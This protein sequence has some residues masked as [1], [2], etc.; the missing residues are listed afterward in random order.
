MTTKLQ[1]VLGIINKY[2]YENNITKEC[3]TNVQIIF[4]YM[5]THE[6]ITPVIIKPVIAVIK[7]ENNLTI[8]TNH[9]VIKID[10][11]IIDPSYEYNKYSNVVYYEN[12]N[13]FIINTF[14]S[15][16]KGLYTKKM[17]KRAF[18]EFRKISAKIN[19]TKKIMR[20]N[21]NYYDLLYTRISNILD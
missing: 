4:Q 14:G 2:Q 6:P 3:L 17:Y 12:Y 15:N 16:Y 13:D 19:K 7:C 1:R 11:I 18:N 20:I 9:V 8:C 10:D 21:N 5:L